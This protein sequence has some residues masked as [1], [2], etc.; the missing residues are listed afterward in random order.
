MTTAN[1]TRS[2]ASDTT[3]ANHATAKAAPKTGRRDQLIKLLRRKSGVD[4]PAISETFG[5]QP[6]S[7]RAALS[8]L[9]K[10]G[11]DVI[12]EVPAKGKPARYRIEQ[13]KLAPHAAEMVDAG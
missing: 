4:L 2:I 12:R 13:A 1:N 6:H 11:I 10:A 7:A 8:G 9:R 5:W 3:S